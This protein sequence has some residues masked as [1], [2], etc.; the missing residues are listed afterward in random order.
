M[1]T[2]LHAHNRQQESLN[3]CFLTTRAKQQN[4][5][6]DSGIELNSNE[7]S[8]MLYPILSYSIVSYRII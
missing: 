6:L 5:K 2:T 3:D 8:I 1:P 4:D 7:N